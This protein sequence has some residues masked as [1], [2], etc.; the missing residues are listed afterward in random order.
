MRQPEINESTLIT[1]S[2]TIG[3]GNMKANLPKPT[4]NMPSYVVQS[5]SH[6]GRKT[7]HG[8]TKPPR[9]LKYAHFFQAKP[10]AIEKTDRTDGPDGRTGRTREAPRGCP[11][12][13]APPPAVKCITTSLVG[14]NYR[15]SPTCMCVRVCPIHYTL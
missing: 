15:R 9:C 5:M 13:R 8:T 6:R 10:E 1:T 7:R 14:R 12:V 2:A 4:G 3:D 11:G